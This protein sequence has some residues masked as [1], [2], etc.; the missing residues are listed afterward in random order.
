VT[1]HLAP[2]EF[3]DLLDGTLVVSDRPHLT[4]CD[5]CRAQLAELRESWQQ[6]VETQ[7]PEPSPLFWDH[8]SA[9]VHEA[10]TAEESARRRWSWPHLSWRVIAVTSA[11]AVL[12]FVVTLVVRQPAAPS[13]PPRTAA[14]ESTAA[15]PVA[16]PFAIE[17]DEPLALVADLASELDWENTADAGLTTHEAAERVVADLTDEEREELQ[18]LLTDAI[19]SGA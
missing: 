1:R 12:A 2:E 4:E 15:A 8:F 3:V 13:E 18:R 9:R 19:S 14:V 11:V 7:V 16:A 5:Q 6:A 10:I 17:D